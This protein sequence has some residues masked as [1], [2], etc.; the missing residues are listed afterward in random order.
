MNTA[1]NIILIVMFGGMGIW[2]ATGYFRT[3]GKITIYD[4]KWT[5]GRILF[6]AAGVL[7]LMTL[8]VYSEMIDYIRIFCMLFCIV[9]YV[10]LRD[11]IG[12]EGA[13][14]NGSFVSWKEIRGYDYRSEKNSFN[15]VFSV[16][17]KNSSK[18]GD[19]T[20]NIAFAKEDEEA[21]RALLKKKAGKKF[22]RMKK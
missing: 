14:S 10:L 3:K 13:C 20:M 17:D 18:S 15:V 12:E 21:V 4:K 16:W 6:I 9:S 8:A 2:L 19:Y 1:S 11:G 5:P 7:S 22:M